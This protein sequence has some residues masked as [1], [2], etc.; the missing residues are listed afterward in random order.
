L[1]V[2]S[3]DEVKEAHRRFTESGK[4]LGVSELFPLQE[5][6]GSAAFYLRDPASNCWEISTR[7]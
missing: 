5:S 7:N 4:E 6:N 1:V 3:K 2:E